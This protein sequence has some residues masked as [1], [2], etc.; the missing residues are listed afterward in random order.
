MKLSESQKFLKSIQDTTNEDGYLKSLRF[1]LPPDSVPV[2]RH[3]HVFDAERKWRFDF[4]VPEAMVAIEID[5][6]I[7]SQGRHVRG[8]GFER[9]HQKLNRAVILGWRVLRFTRAMIRSGQAALDTAK[10]LE[11]RP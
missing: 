11:G 7:Y 5:G 4:A 6:G 3:E 1:F 8:S 10:I 9:D 2:L